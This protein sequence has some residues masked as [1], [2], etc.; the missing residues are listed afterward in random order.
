MKT[1]DILE[2]QQNDEVLRLEI[3][4]SNLYKAYISGDRDEMITKYIVAVNVNILGFKEK[5]FIE[6]RTVFIS[7]GRFPRTE[8]YWLFKCSAEGD[9]Y[10]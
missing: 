5:V 6:S 9:R 2:Q 3:A 10:S 7:D 8:C 1:I 4:Y